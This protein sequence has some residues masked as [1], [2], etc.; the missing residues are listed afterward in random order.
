M[1]ASDRERPSFTGANG[2]VI[3]ALIGHGHALLSCP[4]SRNRSALPDIV[5]RSDRRTKAPDCGTRRD[6]DRL[7]QP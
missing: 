3:M 1:P 7:R 2:T 5:N 6:D 4:S